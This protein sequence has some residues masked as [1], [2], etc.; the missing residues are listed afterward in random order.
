MRHTAK[1]L[2]FFFSL[3]TIVAFIIGFSSGR[4]IERINTT[5]VPPTPTPTPTV[6]PE[7]T[8]MPSSFARITMKECGIS[9]VLPEDLEDLSTAEN[10]YEYLV[11]KGKLYVSCVQDFVAD[12]NKSLR[13]DENYATGS[14]T[15]GS[16]T[17]TTYRNDETDIWFVRNTD[18]DLVLIE[19]S[20]SLTPLVQQTLEL[21]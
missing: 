7:V 1:S 14:A 9:A 16:Q 6:M 2:I 11:G 4:Y 8:P 5:Y 3:L 18:R 10:E 17:V 20:T 21:L 12:Q 19:T 15:F 13:D